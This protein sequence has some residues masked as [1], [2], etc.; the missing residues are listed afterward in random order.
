MS[1]EKKSSKYSKRIDFNQQES[2]CACKDSFVAEKS[3]RRRG[4]DRRHDCRRSKT[5]SERSNSLLS[6]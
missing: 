4:G 3:F 6:R 1:D 2:D 5:V